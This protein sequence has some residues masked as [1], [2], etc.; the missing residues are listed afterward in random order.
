MKKLSFIALSLAF[1]NAS[2]HAQSL[3]SLFE[4]G[5]KMAVVDDTIYFNSTAYHIAEG[6]RLSELVRNLPGAYIDVVNGI[7]SIQGENIN[8]IV[9]NGQEFFFNEVQ[10]LRYLPVENIEY[11]KFYERK[12]DLARAT[13]IND[14]NEDKVL[15]IKYKPDMER[16]LSGILNAN[17]FGT[18]GLNL[19]YVKK[20]NRIS[21]ITNIENNEYIPLGEGNDI[22]QEEES[23]NNLNANL[24][25]FTHAKNLEIG[26]SGRLTLY[27]ERN[28][29]DNTFGNLPKYN[30]QY[31]LHNIGCSFKN[32]FSQ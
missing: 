29:V 24:D 22:K 23:K 1:M 2:S 18:I 19:D 25:F 27:R 17:H 4:N 11:I 26:G 7:T 16:R 31:D 10:A 20:G 21:L 30:Y 5:E 32:S 8:K 15:D 9:I 14:A 3:N 6:T 28:M 12:S 13:G